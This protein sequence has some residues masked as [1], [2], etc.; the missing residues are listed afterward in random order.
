MIQLKRDFL[1]LQGRAK[2]DLFGLVIG[3]VIDRDAYILRHEGRH[4]LYSRN[5]Y[6]TVLRLHLFG[7]GILYLHAKHLPFYDRLRKAGL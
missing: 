6:N 2:R 4:V 7:F 5:R 1:H 3:R